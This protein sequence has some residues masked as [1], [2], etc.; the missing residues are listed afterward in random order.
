[1]KKMKKIFAM[2]LSLAMV[3]GMSLTAWADPVYPNASDHAS[4][5]VN[6][7]SAGD[8]VSF[9]KIVEPEYVAVGEGTS[10]K[11]YK[12]VDGYS[13]DDI[14]H[15]TADEIAAAANKEGKV[16]DATATVATNANSV[17]QDLTIGTYLVLVKAADAKT[18]YNPM[19][20]SVYYD[21]NGTHAG[22][23]DAGSYFTVKSDPIYAKKSTATITKEIVDYGDSGNN[24]GADHAIGDTVKFQI[25][26]DVPSY[27]GDYTTVTYKITD[28]MRGLER[29]RNIKVYLN[30]VAEGNIIEAKN[31]T[32][33]PAAD[34]DRTDRYVINFDSEYI[35]G[36]SS[37]V[38]K[39]EEGEE[40][41]EAV[42]ERVLNKIYVTYE[43]TIS[44]DATLN[45]DA[46]NNTV[47]LDY[48]N[49]PTDIS[50]TKTETDETYH[51]TFAIDSN[52]NGS[53]SW[54][55][56]ELLKT[57][58]KRVL[59]DGREVYTLPGA[60]FK[61]T[62]DTTKKEYT[63][64]SDENG[65]ISFTG[66]DAGT[67]TLE[68]T[69]APVGYTLNTNKIPVEIKAEYETDGQLKSYQIK[70]GGKIVEEDGK[71][72]EKFTKYTWNND[73]TD[74]VSTTVDKDGK[75]VTI[76]K[77]DTSD[78]YEIKNTKLA[79]LPST[80]GIG[81]TIFTIGGCAIM[82]I[83]AGLFFASRRKSD[84]K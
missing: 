39:E 17:Q 5:T 7:L 65:H 13:I 3:L 51:Y 62:N 20:V 68:E 56:E 47:T 25:T 35:K 15:P 18:V 73:K 1:M 26:S 32:I 12:V 84:A 66:L 82:I 70:V 63:A 72:D 19:I 83:A 40:G 41:E 23:V 21:V 67:Y 6:N 38:L 76:V 28:I 36:L 33:D 60:K 16:A 49:D 11:D 43:A 78:T 22:S 61:L 42:T 31:Y 4:A 46:N 77:P 45:F 34:K 75:P 64:T 74:I 79:S 54:V 2:I 9:Y 59:A 37:G 29:P 30:E 55:T 52:I 81:T 50:K 71:T 80:G 69:E 24:K 58:E 27:S 48:S 10:F 57:G 8:V 44:D 53:D 14:E